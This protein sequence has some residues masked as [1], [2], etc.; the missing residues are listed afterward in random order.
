[1]RGA[2][3]SVRAGRA[4]RSCPDE[5]D[6]AAVPS[7]R[8]LLPS[9]LRLELLAAARG[10]AFA[11]QRFRSWP[12]RR[13]LLSVQGQ[14]FCRGHCYRLPG[15]LRSS[16]ACPHSQPWGALGDVMDRNAAAGGERA[17]HG[18]AAPLLL[19]GAS[20]V[21]GVHVDRVAH[22]RNSCTNG[23]EGRHRPR[24]GS[25][26]VRER[27]GWPV[28]GLVGRG[29]PV[30]GSRVCVRPP[31]VVLRPGRDVCRSTAQS[32]RDPSP[33]SARDSRLEGAGV[34]LVLPAARC[35]RTAAPRVAGGCASRPASQVCVRRLSGDGEG[36]SSCWQPVGPPSLPTRH[37]SAP[38]RLDVDGPQQGHGQP[39]KQQRSAPQRPHGAGW[40]CRP[41]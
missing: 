24:R 2:L 17:R 14:I 9:G 35:A 25:R 15:G 16:L 28:A 18:L 31:V 1:M 11:V 3:A 23:R 13:A 26:P 36:C 4:R 39:S 22:G 29:G 27:G 12:A 21:S 7:T 19:C 34:A 6:A 40:L 5:S 10:R 41:L 32:A 8:M 37:A 30:C 33:H 20:R 38:C